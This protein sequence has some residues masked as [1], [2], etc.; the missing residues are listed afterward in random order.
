MPQPTPFGVIL[1]NLGTPQA[2]TPSAIRQYLS[3]FLWDQRVVDA[4]RW[5]WWLLLH[6]IILRLRPRKVARLYQGIWLADGS[7]L[8]HYSQS[9]RQSIEAKLRER[10][11]TEIPV[12]LAM[13][14]GHPNFIDASKRFRQQGIHK[15]IVLPLFPQYSAT[16]TAAAFD[17]LAR[18]LG[19]CPDVPEM[20]WIR[21]YHDEP[22]YLEALAQ[23]VSNHWQ[24]HGQGDFLLM[25]FHGIPQRYQ[26][27]GDPYP[28]QCHETARGLAALLGLESTQW[29]ASFQSRFGREAWVEPYTDDTAALL[30]QRGIKK[31][32]VICPAFAVDCL[33]TLE[34]IKEQIKDTFISAGG[35]D[36][37]YIPC[38]NDSPAHT[39][40]LTDVILRRA[41]AF[42]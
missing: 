19:Q 38:L 39:E 35:T 17:S 14:Y 28:D 4:P 26:D 11:G 30:A 7:P 15:I 16:T 22:G 36:L 34:E 27:Q 6:G 32:D 37:N 24:Q 29:Q 12:E 25:S 18:Q 23:S 8:L 13:T 21:Q 33:E 1:V 3:E 5:L 20:L 40:F 41:Q 2:P 42:G 9:L 10:Q 31:L